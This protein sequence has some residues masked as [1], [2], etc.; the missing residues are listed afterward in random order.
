MDKTMRRRLKILAVVIMLLFFGTTCFIGGFISSDNQFTELVSTQQAELNR[1]HLAERGL[2][3]NGVRIDRMAWYYEESDGFSTANVLCHTDAEFLDYCQTYHPDAVYVSN[4]WTED[5]VILSF[6][7]H[8]EI[9]AYWQDQYQMTGFYYTWTPDHR[10]C[11]ILDVGFSVE[12]E[13]YDELIGGWLVVDGV[14]VK[15]FD[16]DIGS[17]EPQALLQDYQNGDWDGSRRLS[18]DWGTTGYIGSD[19]RL[20]YSYWAYG[21]DATMDPEGLAYTGYG[22]PWWVAEDLGPELGALLVEPKFVSFDKTKGILAEGSVD[23]RLYPDLPVDYDASQVVDSWRIW[24]T[25]VLICL[26]PTRMILAQRGK[27][28]TEWPLSENPNDGLPL[29]RE[30]FQVLQPAET[31]TAE[32]ANDLLYVRSGDQL[33]AL[34]ADG[35]VELALGH[36]VWMNGDNPDRIWGLQ[37]GK[38]ICWRGATYY[39]VSQGPVTVAEGVLDVDF[40]G[41]SALVQKADGCYALIC[42]SG[43]KSTYSLEYLGTESLEYYKRQVEILY[44]SRYSR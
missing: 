39:S 23:V 10:H 24:Q 40:T 16:R 28:L 18:S 29:N 13:S 26:E 38:L 41:A 12:P 14:R 2:D 19:G 7:D 44:Q 37:N 34:R 35:T 25:D 15:A 30:D 5:E 11:F 43:A 27:I 21:Y 6:R 9:W 8:P 32:Y 20:S 4:E 3:E 31:R 17:V 22:E 36:I 1:I 33:W 42:E